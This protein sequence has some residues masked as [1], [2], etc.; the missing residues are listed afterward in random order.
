MSALAGR[1]GLAYGTLEQ[2]GSSAA[3][4]VDKKMANMSTVASLVSYRPYKIN[5]HNSKICSLTLAHRSML[6]GV[7]INLKACLGRKDVVWAVL[8]VTKKMTVLIFAIFCPRGLEGERQ[9]GPR[10]GVSR[11]KGH[12]TGAQ[13]I[14]RPRFWAL[15]LFA[16]GFTPPRRTAS[17]TGRRRSRPGRAARCACPSRR[18]RRRGSPGSRRRC[19]SWTGGAR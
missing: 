7:L 5:E 14:L 6:P 10:G 13:F 12:K 9:S 19:G 2:V 8:A 4:P 3:Y 18:C 16:A 1:G 11:P 15:R 17:C